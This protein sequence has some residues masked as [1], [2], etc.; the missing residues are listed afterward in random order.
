MGDER[1]D[2]AEPGDQ[3]KLI[4][5]WRLATIMGAIL[6]CAFALWYFLTQIPFVIDY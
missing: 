2:Y 5:L 6:F 4:P 3:P 1:R